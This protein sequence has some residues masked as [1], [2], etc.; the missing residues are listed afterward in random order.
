MKLRIRH[1]SC[2]SQ[3]SSEGLVCTSEFNIIVILLL[4]KQMW[5]WQRMN[6]IY[7]AGEITLITGLLIWI[8]SLPQVRRMRFEI[9][10][11]T[12]H[13]YAVFLLFFLFHGG[14]RHFYMVFPGIFLFGLD[15]L[16]RIIQSRPTTCVLSARVFPCEA[17]ELILPKDPSKSQ[18]C[19]NKFT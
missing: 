18:P 10:Y 15:K 12:H 19:Y 2:N 4:N 7:L 13:L 9:F 6:R 8:T 11:Y 14:D 1:K 16:L 17:V 5:K 3:D